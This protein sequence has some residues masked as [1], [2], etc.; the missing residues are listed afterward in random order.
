MKAPVL[1][2]VLL[3]GLVLPLALLTVAWYMIQVITMCKFLSF[4]P[5]HTS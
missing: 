5:R 1:Q 3:Y 2:R 4:T